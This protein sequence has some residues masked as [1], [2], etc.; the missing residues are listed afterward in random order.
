MYYRLSLS[1]SRN[2]FDP[3]RP[4]RPPK[5]CRSTSS[6]G[7]AV[8]HP[9]R[10]GVVG[11]DLVECSSLCVD[12]AEEQPSARYAFEIVFAAL[13]EAEAGASHEVDDGAGDQD[14]IS[15]DEG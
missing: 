7:R 4:A 1:L 10:R 15:L 2:N 12:D 6:T 11:L 9:H 5:H 14:L 3:R 13:G 8:L